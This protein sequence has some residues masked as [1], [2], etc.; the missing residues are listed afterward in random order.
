MNRCGDHLISRFTQQAGRI[1]KRGRIASSLVSKQKLH[2]TITI[3][4]IA[5]W[6]KP[7]ISGGGARVA[8]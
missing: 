8:G 5:E 3:Q 6:Q 4:R 1:A 2:P 7:R